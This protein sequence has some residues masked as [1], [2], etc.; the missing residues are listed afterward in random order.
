MMSTEDGTAA[1]LR[2]DMRELGKANLRRIGG[3]LKFSATTW[4][5][6]GETGHSR[7]SQDDI[8]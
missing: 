7:S 3:D 1:I 8:A 4:Q 5:N 6:V 2:L